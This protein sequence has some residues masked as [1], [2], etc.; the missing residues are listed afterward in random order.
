MPTITLENV[1]K[2]Y[3]SSDYIVHAVD[4]VTL[5]VEEGESVA[6]IGPS[7]SGKSTLLNMMGLVL[8]PEEGRVLLDG[9]DVTA[10]GDSA[11]SQL[12][13]RSFGYIFQD[14]ALLD[15]ET[16]YENI[17][18]PLIYNREIKRSEHRQRIHAAA[19]SLGIADKLRR[20]AAKLSGGERQRVAIS[21]AFVCDQPILLAD[22]PTGALDA[23]NK[24]NV[25]E[26]LMKLCRELN[27]T[28]V[29]VT[30]DPAVSARCDRVLHM[31]DGQLV[32]EE[33]PL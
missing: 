4:H 30:H 5:T 13:N 10:L 8:K 23:E 28:L 25:L 32:D 26:L 27:R 11:C 31:K 20:K 18:L 12:R 33:V 15:S 19:E 3:K 14:F 7:G 16:V 17:R 22:E 6:I 2:S 9:E 1:C 24:E 29:V 21:R